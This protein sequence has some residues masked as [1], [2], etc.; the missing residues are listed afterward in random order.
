MDAVFSQE[1]P[2]EEAAVKCMAAVQVMH[3]SPGPHTP[4]VHFMEGTSWN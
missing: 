1:L 4:K 2:A 3:V